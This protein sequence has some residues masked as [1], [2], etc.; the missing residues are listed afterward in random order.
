MNANLFTSAPAR[1]P[2]VTDGA[3]N[4]FVFA[5]QLSRAGA[6]KHPGV[7]MEIRRSLRMHQR[8][9]VGLMLI[10]FML[11]AIYLLNCISISTASG[12]ES[13]APT[14]SGGLIKSTTMEWLR[15]EITRAKSEQ[16]GK[17]TAAAHKR[18][19]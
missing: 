7:R 11:G 1:M 6:R 14:M 13:T 5:S 12:A 2:R 9:A 10:G 3:M 4:S 8:L 18:R 15:K 19:R 17:E 16:R